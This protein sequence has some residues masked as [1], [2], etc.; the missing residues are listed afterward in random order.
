MSTGIE[1]VKDTVSG[2]LSKLKVDLSS[3]KSIYETC[4]MAKALIS[5]RTLS[6]KDVNDSEFAG[7][8]TKRYYAPVENRPEG[9][10]KPAGGR[11]F[12]LKNP[13]KPLKTMAFDAGYGQYKVGIGRPSTPQLSISGQMLADM[14]TTVANPREGELYFTSR[15]SAAKAHGHVTGGNALP[16]RDFF[17]INETNVDQLAGKLATLLTGYIA[18]AGLA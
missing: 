9:Y 13:K 17:G 18:K 1:V 15:N 5:T 2:G 16:V 3:E 4:E 6:G 8:S 10:P 11:S 7:Y 14:A 12:Y